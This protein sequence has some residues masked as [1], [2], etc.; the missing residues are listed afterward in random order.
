MALAALTLT[1]PRVLAGEEPPASAPSEPAGVTW[2]EGF[3][4]GRQKAAH[5]GRLM[6]VYVHRTSPH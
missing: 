5:T 3:E 4:A 6:L 2:V 1:S